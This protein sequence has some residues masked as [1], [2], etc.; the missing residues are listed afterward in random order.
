MLLSGIFTP[1]AKGD[2]GYDE[3]L[4]ALTEDFLEIF[5]VNSFDELSEDQKDYLGETVL[6]F[7]LLQS[8]LPEGQFFLDGV[9]GDQSGILLQNQAAYLST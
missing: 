3:H 5:E 7:F 4:D 8:F 6:G 9:V 2:V 1:P